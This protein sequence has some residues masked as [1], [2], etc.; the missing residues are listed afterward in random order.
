MTSFGAPRVL[1]K[2]PERGVFALDH[3]GECKDMMRQ[4]L[5]CLKQNKGRH[6][7]CRELSGSYLT[8]RMERDLMAKDDLSN[9][10]LG[11]LSSGHVRPSSVTNSKREGKMLASYIHTLSHSLLPTNSTLMFKRA[12]RGR[13]YSR[14]WC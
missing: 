4:Y 6:F 3:D 8:C 7:D 13:F 11:E 12:Y 1:V 14:Y 9:L 10:G 5:A 2:P